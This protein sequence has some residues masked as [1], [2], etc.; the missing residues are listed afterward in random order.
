MLVLEGDCWLVVRA[1]VCVCVCVYEPGRVCV[2]AGVSLASEYV[3]KHG[4]FS[5]TSDI[6][7]S[8][9]TV[10]IRERADQVCGV[11]QLTDHVAVWSE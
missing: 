6:N 3:C 2:L 7:L 9:N 10:V 5:R 4:A 8:N 1:R 11:G